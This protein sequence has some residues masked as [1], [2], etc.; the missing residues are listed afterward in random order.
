MIG[1]RYIPNYSIYLLSLIILTP[2]AVYVIQ[3]PPVSCLIM[4]GFMIWRFI[5]HDNNSDLRNQ[6]QLIIFMSFA[7]ILDVIFFYDTNLIWAALIMLAVI[8]GGYQLSH[9]VV[10]GS[11][12]VKQSLPF[13]VGFLVAIIAG[14]AVVFA[15]FQAAR[16]VAP[17][18]FNG[19]I[20][21]V[22]AG[23]WWGLD[24][25]G[26]TGLDLEPLQNMIEGIANQNNVQMD[27]EGGGNSFISEDQMN[28][29]YDPPDVF[30]W[31]T[32]GIGIVILIAVIFFLSRRKLRD[33]GKDK[34]MERIPSETTQVKF[35]K[36]AKSRGLFGKFSEKP[37]NEIRLKVFK[38]EQLTAQNGLGRKQSETIEQWFGRIGIDASYLNI[39]QKVRYG[40][41]D[42]SEDEVNLFNKQLERIKTTLDL[43]M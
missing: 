19:L 30:N 15:V 27:M 7:C 35:T 41:S 16:T 28:S 34:A 22:S 1:I 8:V 10:E 31:W 4:I 43:Q 25:L 14:S 11:I 23:I 2:F 5:I 26:F 9:I 33:Q 6:M 39:Y 32:I 21:I 12:G 17:Y 29:V 42:L 38:F 13:L 20:K 24:L 40:D 18:V 3:F 37:T 36:K